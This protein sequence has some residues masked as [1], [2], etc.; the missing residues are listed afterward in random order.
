MANT[1][2][3]I[4][5]F[6]HL[7]RELHAL[8]PDR[9]TLLC[10]NKSALFMTQNP[11][12]HKR[13]RHIDLDYHFIRELVKSGKLFTNFVPTNLQLA[14]MVATSHALDLNL[15]LFHVTNDHTPV[16]DVH[17]SSDEEDDECSFEKN[18][19]DH[20]AVGDLSRITKENKKLKEM[21][22]VVW[23][24]YTTLQTQVKKIMQDKE[25]LPRTCCPISF[26]NSLYFTQRDRDGLPKVCQ[27]SWDTYKYIE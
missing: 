14:T 15:N 8:P 22:T 16:V 10:D 6:T 3:E 4:I 9:P 17:S 7:L 12:S 24:K 25:T 26:W 27:K 19:D 2:T 23:D 1:A 18:D 13:A 20:N 11:V 21:L 5:W